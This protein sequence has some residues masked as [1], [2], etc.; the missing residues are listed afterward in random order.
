MTYYDRFRPLAPEDVDTRKVYLV[1]GGLAALAAAFVAIRDAKMP[2]ENITILEMNQVAGGG[3]DGAGNAETG[4][5]LR[6][7]REMETDYNCFWDLFQDVPAFEMGEGYSVLDEFHHIDDIDPNYSNCRLMH[8][9]GEPQD[10]SSFGLDRAQQMEIIK[11]F[12]AD[13]NALQGLAIDQYFSP[14]FLQSNFWMFW[15]TMFAFHDWESLIEVK[16]YMHRF[17]HCFPGFKDMSVVKFC[18]YNQYDAFI[19]P[20]RDLLLSKGVRFEYGA[21]VLDLDMDITP[22]RKVVTAIR[23]EQNGEPRTIEVDERDLVLV[24]NGSLTES[25][26]YGDMA[27]VPPTITEEHGGCWNLWRTLAAKD[28]SFGR[29]DVFCSDVAKTSWESF[30]ITARKSA[31]TDKIEQLSGRDPFARKTT[32]GGI[33]TVT[34]SSWLLS[35]TVNRQPQFPDQPEDV[36][37]IWGYGLLMD[38]VGDHVEKTMPECTGEEILRELCY[39]L[40]I[41]DSWDDVLAN[42]IN[43]PTM[44]PYITSFFQV[45]RNGDRPEAVPEGSVNLAFMGEFVETA[46]DC[47]F[48]LDSA[49]RTGEEGIYQLLGLPKKAPEFVTK[50]YDI[51]YLAAA[52]RALNDDKPL[53]LEPVVARVAQH[54]YYADLFPQAATDGAAPRQLAGQAR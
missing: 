18:K 48:T 19:K 37:V 1:G 39:H 32:T 28:P 3:I 10:N 40:G 50:Q 38:T 36:V 30:T 12:M 14:G 8:N 11:L 31:L 43:I 53:P 49:I 47:S 26:G 6:G 17:V 23:L 9:Q 15:R 29:P 20:L 4:Y 16:R 2:G 35:F 33:I 44:L 42:S 13:E 22:Q 46:Q 41:L 27:T 24:T 5:V 52:A 54:S 21:N 7:G 34:D 25:T 51:R 45:R